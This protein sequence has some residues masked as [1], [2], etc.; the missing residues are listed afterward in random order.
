M[1]I[2]GKWVDAV[3]GDTYTTL[4][5]ATEEPIGT[6]PMGDKRDVDIAVEAA[7]RAFPVWS[8][9]SVEERSMILNKIN[10]LI[11]KRLQEF[12][13]IDILGH[14]TPVNMAIMLSGVIAN[15]F[16]GAAELGKIVLTTGEINPTSRQFGY[17]QREPIGVCGIIEPWNVPFMIGTRIA[18]ALA[19]GNTCV[20][21]PPS[22]CSLT[23]LKYAEILAEICELT[24][25]A[26]NIVTGPGNTAGE[27]IA[28]HPDVGGVFFTGSNETGKAIMAAASKTVKRI[29]L[30]LGGKNPFIVLEDAD[31]H[32]ALPKAVNGAYFNTGM[33]CG[34]P[35][36]F[37]IHEKLY[38]VFVDKFVA[39]SKKVV[40]GDP[41][42][43]NTFMGPVISAEHRDRVENY[44]KIGIE[45]GAKLVLGGKRPAEPPLNR[46]YYM[47][48]TVFTEVTQNMR[49]AR[50]EIFGP[51]ACFIKFSSDEEVLEMAND[52]IYGL[53][54]S[55][56]TRDLAKGKIFAREIQ[57]GTVSINNHASGLTWG[58]YKQSGFGKTNGILGQEEFTQIKVINID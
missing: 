21:K 29:S 34:A 51:V 30:E 20:V 57:A 54:S 36:R 49:I 4:N 44:I 11:Q 31:I 13:D 46:G 47:V 42:D 5:P 35:G 19:V 32:L 15:T 53:T 39:E 25:G 7:R 16:A 55:V 24:P 41:R 1:W 33:I 23:A 18:A 58:G 2:D 26:V 10:A 38:D 14:G 50:E 6:I 17:L 12:I 52:T 37:Y 8:H 22:V 27:A 45:E 56:W 3:S 43:K 48:P 28:S 40:V 9:K